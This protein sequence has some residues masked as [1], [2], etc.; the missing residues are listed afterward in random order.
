MLATRLV[1]A[2]RDQ[3]DIE[4][5]LTAVFLFPTLRSMAAEVERIL[6]AEIE[7]LSGADAQLLLGEET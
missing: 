6:L 2:M 7:A 5:P 3:F 1:T 4:L